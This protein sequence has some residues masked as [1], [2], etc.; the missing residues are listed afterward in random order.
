MSELEQK[1]K[2]EL[3][4][5]LS[6]HN[7]TRLSDGFG[8]LPITSK[9]IKEGERDYLTKRLKAGWIL[10]EDFVENYDTIV[11]WERVK[12]FINDTRRE[13]RRL[14]D[15]VVSMREQ[16]ADVESG[17]WKALRPML[18]RYREI[19]ISD[20]KTLSTKKQRLNEAK[21]EFRPLKESIKSL[22]DKFK[23]YI[24]QLEVAE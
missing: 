12:D 17:K 14:E 8:E 13:V 24:S 22:K 18:P 20:L 21:I 5:G 11:K 1:A 6:F 7:L 2:E 10:K 19:L 16:I 23:S 4:A 15:G 3:M 9:P